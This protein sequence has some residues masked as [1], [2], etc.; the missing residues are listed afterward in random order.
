MK[1][2]KLGN[3]FSTEKSGFT[4]IITI[5][6]GTITAPKIVQF[7]K[8]PSE[9]LGLTLKIYQILFYH[10]MLLLYE[11]ILDISFY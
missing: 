8:L 4:G 6:S 9:I 11:M 1:V 3:S 5:L 2:V 10:Q 7:T